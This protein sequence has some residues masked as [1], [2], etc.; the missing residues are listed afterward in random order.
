[1]NARLRNTVKNTLFAGYFFML[2]FLVFLAPHRW[3]IEAQTENR[4]HLMPFEGVFDHG[5]IGRVFKDRAAFV[6]YG[7]LAGNFLLLMPAA[8]YLI[9]SGRTASVNK[10]CLMAL[11]ASLAIE[12]IQYVFVIGVADVNDVI[13]NV[14]GALAAGLFAI[15]LRDTA[16][17]KAI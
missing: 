8:F 4:V 14:S 13:M 1:M 3:E 7:D 5:S 15:L 2:V 17:L 9:F 10:V 16:G 12:L 6:A 11:T